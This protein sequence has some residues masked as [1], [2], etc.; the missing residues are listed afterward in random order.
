MTIK[1]IFREDAELVIDLFNQYRMFYKKES[2]LALARSFI[3]ERLDHN[4]SVIFVVMEGES[5]IGFTQLYPKYSSGQAQKNWILNDLFVTPLYRSEGAGS[6][7]IEAAL[8][9]AKETG[10]KFV[11]LETAVD[12]LKAQSL[13]EYI[14]FAKQLPDEDFLVYRKQI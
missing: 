12:N 13:Y 6:M 11:Q 7:L 3:N 10:A 8:E 9:F 4:E 2:D 14:G 5:P 1:R